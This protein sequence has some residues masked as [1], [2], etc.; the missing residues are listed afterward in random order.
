MPRSTEP[1]PWTYDGFNLDPDPPEGGGGDGTGGGGTTTVLNDPAAGGGQTPPAGGGSAPP[2]DFRT[3]L[4]EE[5]AND[6]SMAPIKDLEGLA[7]GYVHAQRMVGRDKVP[8]PADD[9]AAGWE[10]VYNRLGRP[11]KPEDYDLS[12][13]PTPE[14]VEVDDK[15]VDGFKAKAHEMGLNARQT[16]QMY[17][18]Y[19]SQTG[20]QLAST[21]QAQEQAYQDAERSLRREFGEAYDQ[22]LNLAR[23]AVKELG[24]DGLMAKLDQSGLG[25]DPDMI[26]FLARA[27]QQIAPDDL[28]GR[29]GPSRVTP[30]EARSRI[31]ERQR[32]PEFVKAYTDGQHPGHAQAVEEMKKLHEAATAGR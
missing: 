1:A 14:G 25:N 28:V 19:M 10:S 32:D 18:W 31:A 21:Q 27:G 4:P 24:G 6:P 5:L 2:G 11:E 29:G 23:S 7:K 22:H 26:K 20:E 8:I 3:Q 12:Q 13:T 15:L 9:D 17:D 30:D 16:A